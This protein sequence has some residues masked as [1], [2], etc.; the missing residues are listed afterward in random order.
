[1]AGNYEKGGNLRNQKKQFIIIAV[2]SS[3]WH[4]IFCIYL[5]GNQ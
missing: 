5:L 1:M 2:Q 4:L 3:I